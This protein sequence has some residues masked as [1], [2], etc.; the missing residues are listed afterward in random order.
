MR[1]GP[2][3]L[4]CGGRV[5]WQEVNVSGCGDEQR[6]YPRGSALRGFYMVCEDCCSNLRQHAPYRSP[7][8]ANEASTIIEM[9]V[10]FSPPF[11][12][13]GDRISEMSVQVRIDPQMPF[14]VMVGDNA[15]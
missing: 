6:A 2:F 13:S 11:M 15:A 7:A 5:R 12:F 9:P 3:P 8:P 10:V 1:R 14:F 4:Q